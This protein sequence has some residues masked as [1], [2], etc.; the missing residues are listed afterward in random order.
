MLLVTQKML[1]STNIIFVL[2]LL[3]QDSIFLNEL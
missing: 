2:E 3:V 1:K